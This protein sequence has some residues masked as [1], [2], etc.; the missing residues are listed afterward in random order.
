MAK[1]SEGQVA[2]LLRRAGVPEDKVPL[3]V[4]IAKRESGLNPFAHNPDRST[5]DNSYGLFQIN[6]IDEPG[7]QLG[8]ERLQQFADLGVRNYEDLKDPWKNAQAAARILKGSGINAWTTAQAASSDPT[9]NLTGGGAFDL[10]ALRG[11]QAAN[12]RNA[13]ALGVDPVAAT[14]LAI[15]GNDE[16]RPVANSPK[17]LRMAAESP[18]A[19]AIASLNPQTPQ[20]TKQIVDAAGGLSDVATAGSMQG[21]GDFRVIEYLT[22]D[23]SHG[24]FRQDHGGENYHEHLAFSSPE[25]ARAAASVLNQAGIKTTELKGVSTVGGHSPNS[26]HY[27][28][29]AFD[30]PAAQVPRGQEQE[31]S[32]RVRALLR[33]A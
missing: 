32:R 4:N 14:G 11:P 1:L 6:M 13:K 10:A 9:P 19:V 23:A 12:P 26:Y 27:S 15:I 20:E 7:Y 21:G 2:E 24:G 31:L 5:G 25:E 8:Q 3:M 17:G 28:G 30:V 16:R 33:M 29:Q 18:L 22:G